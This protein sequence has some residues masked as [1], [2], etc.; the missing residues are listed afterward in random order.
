MSTSGDYARACD[1]GFEAELL[2]VTL[3]DGRELRVPLEWYPTLR[4]ATPED[5]A[6]WRLIGGGIGIHWERLDEDLSVRGLLAPRLGELPA[7][8]AP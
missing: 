1:V 7:R 6:A 3:E 2:I 5:R 8:Q 4:D